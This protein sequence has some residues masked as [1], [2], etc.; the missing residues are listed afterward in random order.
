MNSHKY[1]FAANSHM[2]KGVQKVGKSSYLLSK[3]GKLQTGLK[4]VKKEHL[5]LLQPQDLPEVL[6]K[7]QYQEGLLLSQQKVR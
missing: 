1:Y 6:Q 4:K 3:S 2:L 5:Q 7:R